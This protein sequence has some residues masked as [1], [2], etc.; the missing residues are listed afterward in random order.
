M[1]TELALRLTDSEKNSQLWLKIK[2]HL[3]N[4]NDRDRRRNDDT[5]L[6]EEE[7]R[8]LRCTIKVRKE[9]LNLDF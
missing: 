3:E 1:K 6:T 5:A 7:T 8:V 4:L 2:E 9:L